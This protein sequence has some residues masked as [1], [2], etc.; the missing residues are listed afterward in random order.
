MPVQSLARLSLVAV[1]FCTAASAEAALIHHWKFDEGAGPV[2]VDLVGG[3]NGTLQNGP[4]RTSDTPPTSDPNVDSIA[5]D[6]TNQRVLLDSQIDLQPAAA[7]SVSLWYKGQEQGDT[8]WG[9]A[10]VGWDSNGIFSEIT[11]REDKFTWT[12]H[13]G[14]WQYLQATT[15]VN[16]NAWHHLV[17]VHHANQTADLYVDGVPEVTAGDADTDSV[18]F[19]ILSFMNGW[20]G[21]YTQ[22]Q[23]DDV[24]IYD[25][26]LTQQE[27]IALRAIPEP[28][29][30]AL[31]AGGS[32]LLAR[33]RSR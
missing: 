14:G 9:D 26:T 23:L 31:L 19:T 10:L 27:V 30:V 8:F 12:H 24:R 28:A 32:L 1:L 5:F 11:I 16:N 2:V 7:W 25:H 15:P 29:S 17:M 3:V 4:V 6:G 18:P 33:R 21:V 20:Q 13:N 22:G